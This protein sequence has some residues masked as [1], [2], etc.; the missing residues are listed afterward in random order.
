MSSASATKQ[1]ESVGAAGDGAGVPPVA[2]KGPGMK[3]YTARNQLVCLDHE[4]GPS[5]DP[6]VVEMSKESALDVNEPKFDPAALREALA[7][8]GV[9][10]RKG[11][12]VANAL[13]SRRYA[14][15]SAA[16]EPLAA[17]MAASGV[18]DAAIVDRVHAAAYREGLI[19]GDIVELRGHFKRN[20]VCIV[21]IND[22]VRRGHVLTCKSLRKSIKVNTMQMAPVRGPY[23]PVNAATISFQV[24]GESVEGLDTSDADALI[25]TFLVP[26]FANFFGGSAA[27]PVI[28]GDYII[29]PGQNSRNVI[30]KAS[31]VT[32]HPTNAAGKTEKWGQV[33]MAPH[34]QGCR[35]VAAP[36]FLIEDAEFYEEINKVGYAD[37]GGLKEQLVQIRENIELPIR[38]PKIFKTLGMK[39]P[40]GVLMHG[41]PGCGKTLI[42]KAIANECGVKFLTIAGPEIIS[43][44]RGESEANLRTMFAQAAEA[45]PSILFIDEIDS[46]A[47]N[48]DKGRDEN[49]QKIVATLLTLMDGAYLKNSSVFSLYY[50]NI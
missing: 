37:V 17:A 24:L 44:A 31:A 4:N 14:S 42:A 28:Q 39:P 15:R 12:A 27:R 16:R 8:D 48:R 50:N 5:S 36:S 11:D 25:D 35:L 1:G 29:C 9:S 6:D 18:D 2:P 20:A 41:P 49:M 45:A 23:A 22:D 32:S 47:P 7:R 21:K 13:K 46:I 3:K 33:Q 40:K 30:F 34:P 26:H 38:H 10:T 19:D 43:G